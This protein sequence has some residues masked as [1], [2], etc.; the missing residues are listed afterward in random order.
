MNQ[1]EKIFGNQAENIQ[2]LIS[3]SL[4]EDA[5]EIGDVTSNAIFS[6]NQ[7]VTAIYRARKPGVISGI[8]ILDYFYQDLA[9]FK[10]LAKVQDGAPVSAGTDLYKVTGEV[11]K[12]LQFERPTLNFLTHLSGVSTEVAQWKALIKGTKA[13]IRD[14][15]KTIPGFRALEKYAVRM[16]GGVNHRFNLS[17]AILIKDNHIAKAGSITAAYQKAKAKYPQLEIEI[18]VDNFEQLTE[19]VSCRPDLILL[20]NFSPADCKKAVDLV[21][22][23]IKLEASGGINLENILSYAN[24]GVDYLAIGAITHSAPTLDIGLD[25]LTE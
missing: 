14:T 4:T 2:Q 7:T 3:L 21:G 12:I 18:E 9:E 24:S 13:E 16:G 25:F 20:D 6:E 19:A 10:T 11:K 8:C 17:D 23:K 5:Y 22:G 15:R 1:L